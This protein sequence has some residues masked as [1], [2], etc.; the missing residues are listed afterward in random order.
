MRGADLAPIHTQLPASDVM[1]TRNRRKYRARYL[2]L[3]HNQ[4]LIGPVRNRGK[5][6]GT[7]VQHTFGFRTAAPGSRHFLPADPCLILVSSVFA[8]GFAPLTPVPAPTTLNTPQKISTHATHAYSDAYNDVRTSTGGF[9]FGSE[10][11]RL[12]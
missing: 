4:Q 9:K 8:R 7:Q 3:G 12:S 10:H 2:E 11:L 6:P 1:P 5:T